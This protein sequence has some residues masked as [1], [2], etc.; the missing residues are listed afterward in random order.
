MRRAQPARVRPFLLTTLPAGRAATTRRTILLSCPAGIPTAT[1]SA[2]TRFTAR[3]S[4]VVS[5]PALVGIASITVFGP[6]HGFLPGDW[7]ND[8]SMAEVAYTLPHSEPLDGGCSCESSRG[9]YL[10]GLNVCDRIF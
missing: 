2:A 3:E 4:T 6:V 1:P 10:S 7:K 8:T 5:V 9:A